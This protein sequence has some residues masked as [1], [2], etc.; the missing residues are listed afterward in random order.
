MPRWRALGDSDVAAIG[1]VRNLRGTGLALE[2]TPISRAVGRL[3]LS[4]ADRLR[5]GMS[6]GGSAGRAPVEAY[7][8][9]RLLQLEATS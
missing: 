2:R 4:M 6:W 7:V 9:L 5:Q 3:C 8:W 1:A